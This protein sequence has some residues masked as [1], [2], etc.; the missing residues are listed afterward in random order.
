MVD[1][2][3]VHLP[4]WE[5]RGWLGVAN[6]EVL[7]DVVARLRARSAPT[8]LRWIKG[9]SGNQ[10]NDGADELAKKGADAACTARLPPPP[11]KFLR[12]G[13]SL[14]A[15]TQKLAYKGIRANK[16]H[17]GDRQAT[18]R[19]L[20]RVQ[21]SVKYAALWKGLRKRDIPRKMRDFWWKALHDALRIGSYWKHIPG[22]EDRATCSHILTEC[23]APGQ[24][25]IWD[26]AGMTLTRRMFGTILGAPSIPARGED[27]RKKRGG[28]RLEM[29][30]TMEAAHLIWKLR[31]ERVIQREGNQEQWH[32]DA[33]IRN[34]LLATLNK[35]LKMDQGLTAKRL[36]ARGV[37]RGMVLDTWSVILQNRA[38]LSE[39]WIGKPGVLVGMPWDPGD[40]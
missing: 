35:R 12:M 32:S 30:L 11:V 39:D 25:V 3:T 7:K 2:L 1:G 15:I 9:H 29:I 20:D 26:M 6:A 4:K 31:C 33:E 19:M 38:A 24:K 37:K 22:Y 16:A 8:T 10:G 17:K 21:Q 18:D 23:E 14:R 5:E 40:N 34:R 28:R 13:A 27:A 36:N